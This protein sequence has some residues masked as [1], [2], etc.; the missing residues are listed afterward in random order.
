M[1]AGDADVVGAVNIGTAEETTV[2]ELIDALREASG[3]RGEL[4]AGV[5]RRAAWARS[6]APAST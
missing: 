2:L 6:I 1:A 4:R 3:V 5:R